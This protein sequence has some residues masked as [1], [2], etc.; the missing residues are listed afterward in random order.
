MKKPALDLR[1]MRKG[2][3]E[4]AVETLRNA[5]VIGHF[6]PGERLVEAEMCAAIGISR[7]SL[8][9]ALR[10]LQAERLVD[11]IPN[12]GP[13]IPVMTWAGAEEIFQ[14]RL[15]LEPEAAALAARHG[16]P[17]HHARARAGLAAFAIALAA[18]D[19]GQLISAT[20][21]MYEAITDAAGNGVIQ[22]LQRGLHARISFL[23]AQSMSANNRAATSL[24]EMTAMLDA[25][26]AGQEAQARAATQ[27]HILAARAAA[28]AAYECVHPSPAP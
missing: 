28:K 16:T 13:V 22:E 10:R 24:Q 17:A 26:E 15:L 27:A 4:S 23:R 7:A 11:I 8:R 19:M 25:I 21:E 3:L 9:E 2:V 20:A 6:K 12:R 18:H 5:I 1:I 14:V